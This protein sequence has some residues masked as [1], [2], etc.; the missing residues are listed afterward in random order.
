MKTNLHYNLKSLA[1]ALLVATVGFF[2]SGP[3]AQAQVI[4]NAAVPTTVYPVTTPLELGPVLDVIGYVLSDDY[5]VNL[6]LIPTLT[7]FTGYE[8][9]P[10]LPTPPGSILV[11]T[12]LPRFNVREVVTTVNVWDGQTVVLGGLIS[13]SVQKI[14]DTV[15]VLGDLPLVGVLFRSESKTS[16][17]K[18]L[19]IF[20]TPTIIDQAGNRMHSEDEMPFAQTLIPQ[21]PPATAQPGAQAQP[22]SSRP[23][24]SGS[25]SS[26]RR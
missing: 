16:D 7:E 3:W 15:P 11:P 19:M 4:Q 18:N 6:T 17:K 12:I 13:E 21:Q 9:P 22:Q 5:T 23:A 24:G 14:K 2:A 8:T 10:A 1:A 20:V 25:T 26:P